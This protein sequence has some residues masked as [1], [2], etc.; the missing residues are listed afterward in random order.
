MNYFDFDPHNV[1]LQTGASLR[2]CP[3]N[4]RDGPGRN[5]NPRNW[6]GSGSSHL[7]VWWWRTQDISIQRCTLDFPASTM[8]TDAVQCTQ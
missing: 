4:C 6:S 8:Q 3:K 7:D 5:A 2:S 1:H